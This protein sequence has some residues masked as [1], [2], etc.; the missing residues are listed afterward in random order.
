M[1]SELAHEYSSGG[2]EGRKRFENGEERGTLLLAIESG[3]L[4]M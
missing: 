2:M 3:S 4:R 1:R